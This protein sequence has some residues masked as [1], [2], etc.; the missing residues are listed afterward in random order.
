M[1]VSTL[2]DSPECSRHFHY[3]IL[4]FLRLLL[5]LISKSCDQQPQSN[6]QCNSFDCISCFF[7]FCLSPS[8][9]YLPIFQIFN[10][11]AIIFAHRAENPYYDTKSVI[12]FNSIAIA[13]AC[14]SAVTLA[15]ALVL[16]DL[17]DS[18]KWLRNELLIQ[19]ALIIVYVYGCVTMVQETLDCNGKLGNGCPRQLTATVCTNNI[20]LLF[21]FENIKMRLGGRRARVCLCVCVYWREREKSED[22]SDTEKLLNSKILF[23]LVILRWMGLKRLPIYAIWLSGMQTKL[24]A[25][26]EQQ[27]I[28]IL[29]ILSVKTLSMQLDYT[30][31]ISYFIRKNY[32]YAI[33]GSLGCVTNGITNSIKCALTVRKYGCH[34][35]WNGKRNSLFVF[36]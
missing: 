16:V 1:V 9:F 15:L 25:L 12:K 18:L 26:A 11:L 7:F 34:Y 21:R 2:L 14:F 27:L 4:L 3:I 13:G 10:I 36:W 23:A 32:D 30:I 35:C 19:C 5:C 17:R 22:E 20:F 8:P 28:M 33:S 29:T 6:P 24:T 31:K